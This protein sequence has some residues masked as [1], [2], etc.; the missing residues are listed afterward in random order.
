MPHTV[1]ANESVGDPGRVDP[2]ANTRRGFVG[3]IAD[4]RVAVAGTLTFA[5]SYPSTGGETHVRSIRSIRSIRKWVL[6]PGVQDGATEVVA[7]GSA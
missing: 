3:L 6:P 7:T 2:L 4:E 1:P 5:S